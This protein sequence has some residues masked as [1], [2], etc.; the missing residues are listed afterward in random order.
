VAAARLAERSS[1]TNT[2]IP[3][4]PLNCTPTGGGG[5]PGGGGWRGGGGGGLGIVASCSLSA[6]TGRG[7]GPIRSALLLESVEIAGARRMRHRLFRAAAYDWVCNSRLWSVVGVGMPRLRTRGSSIHPRE[8]MGRSGVL[9]L[10][11]CAASR[12]RRYPPFVLARRRTPTCQTSMQPV[13]A[14]DATRAQLELVAAR[15]SSRGRESGPP[16]LVWSRRPR[17]VRRDP[18]T[19]WTRRFSA[20]DATTASVYRRAH[21]GQARQRPSWRRRDFQEHAASIQFP[22]LR[23]GGR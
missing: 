10:A 5:V 7:R 1:R 22:G 16:A 23:P 18:R 12:V 6:P 13:D 17:Q 9:R 11:I 14:K 8:R 19:G 21:R 4:A 3:L 20:R 15:P 2:R